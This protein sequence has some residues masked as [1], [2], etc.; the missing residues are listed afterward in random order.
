MARNG[1]AMQLKQ[2]KYVSLIII[3]LCRKNKNF[4][5]KNFNKKKKTK[6]NLKLCIF[7]THLPGDRITDVFV[8]IMPTLSENETVQSFIDYFVEQ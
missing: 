6:E 8:E 2:L 4:D 3:N 5:L 1:H 7:T